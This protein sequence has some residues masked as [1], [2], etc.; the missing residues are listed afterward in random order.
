M[1]KKSM[2]ILLACVVLLTACGPKGTPT[3]S[4]GDVEGTAL[5]AAN[6]IVA[7]TML[8]IPTATPFPPTETPS[9]TP[10]PTFTP[11]PLPTLEP[12]QPTNTAQP[13]GACSSVMNIAEAGP[14]SNVRVENETDGTVTFSLYLGAPNAFGQCGFIPGLS[15]LAKN[16]KRVLS[17]P[18]GNYYLYFYGNSAG[19]GSCYVN[20][21]IGDF[22]LFAVKI[23]KN[24]CIVP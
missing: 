3:L 24:A 4:S 18:K 12:I 7:A 16:E 14:Q 5:A 22:H 1:Y 23:R 2:P 19:N 11:L 13:Q 15:P 6:T 17:L 8:A 9:P 21:R 10:L 20:N